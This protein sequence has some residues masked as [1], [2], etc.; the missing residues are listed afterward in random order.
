MIP[1]RKSPET[2]PN[3]LLKGTPAKR[4]ET[5]STWLS[6]VGATDGIILLGGS[7]LTAF[8][9]RV[10]QSHLRADMLPSFW[11]LAGILE[12]GKV[13]VSVPLNLR[14][15]VSEVPKANGIWSY[16]TEV[17]DDP[18]RYPNIAVLRFAADPDS[19]HENIKQIKSQ[20][21]VIDLPSLVLAWL[22]FV[23]GASQQGNPLL[24]GKGLPSAAFVET[25]YGMS[26]IELTPGL[27]SAASCPEAIW[28]SVKWWHSFYEE[29]AGSGDTEGV[30]T[31]VPTGNYVIRQ[32][33]AAV[34]E[35]HK[36]R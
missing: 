25:V 18:G 31:I 17:Y 26:R 11:S 34:V 27:S 3:R 10:A 29:M 36:K 1:I 4:G 8:R 2:K 24:E 12:N 20:R 16:G 32:P 30:E 33:A 14:G 13:I 22:G 15:D 5:N 7:S 9:V 21:G 19:V 6:R 28:Q 23:W 35:E